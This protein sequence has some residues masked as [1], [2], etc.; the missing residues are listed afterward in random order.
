MRKKHGPAHAGSG[1]REKG[2]KKEG[3][4]EGRKRGL[5]A[6]AERA[7]ERRR[8]NGER[9][10]DP[11]MSKNSTEQNYSRMELCKAEAGRT[12]MPERPR[13]LPRVEQN[14]SARASKMRRL[15]TAQGSRVHESVFACFIPSLSHSCLVIVDIRLTHN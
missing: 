10:N 11:R 5:T 3:R 7:S 6:E 13:C 12:D 15:G 1:A 14:V 9:A 8:R 4:K 2:K